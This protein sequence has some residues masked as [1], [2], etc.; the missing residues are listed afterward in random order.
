MAEAFGIVSGAVGIAAIFT[1]CVECF[2]YV[3]IG[4]YFE[5]DYQTALLTLSLLRLRLSRWGAAIHVYEDLQLGQ[6][7]ATSAALQLAKDTVFQIL[8]LLAE[9]AKVSKNF[10]LVA[11]DRDVDGDRG[12]SE[13]KNNQSLQTE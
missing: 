3:Q 10:T 2:E 9:S 4:R 8:V 1:T 13:Q 11:V 7:T 5:R 6:P 12:A